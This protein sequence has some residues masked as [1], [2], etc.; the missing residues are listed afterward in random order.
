MVDLTAQNMVSTATKNQKEWGEE[1]TRI[2][3]DTK[4]EYAVCRVP[5]PLALQRIQ[6]LITHDA[7]QLV[8]S[9]QLVGVCLYVFIRVKHLHAV[10]DVQKDMV[11]VRPEGS[12][13]C[14]SAN[15]A[16]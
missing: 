5:R 9:V 14:C 13:A 12:Q 4:I 3:R 16:Q 8:T 6:A 15:D 7:A 11:K 10:A 1:L 2:V